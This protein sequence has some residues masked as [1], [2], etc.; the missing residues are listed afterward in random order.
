MPAHIQKSSIINRPTN[1]GNKKQGT[2]SSLSNR[3]LF[4]LRNISHRAPPPT[5]TSKRTIS[6]VNQLGAYSFLPSADG[7]TNKYRNY[8]TTIAS[9]FQ[10]TGSFDMDPIFNTSFDHKSIEI[11]ASGIGTTST[12]GFKSA[13]AEDKY[14]SPHY[15]HIGAPRTPNIISPFP[16]IAEHI[17]PDQYYANSSNHYSQGRNLVSNSIPSVINA[18]ANA[19][20]HQGGIVSDYAIKKIKVSYIPGTS[21]NGGD[22]PDMFTNLKLGRLTAPEN[23]YL[24]FFDKTYN[25]VGD[26][27]ILWE[28]KE[29]LSD[30]DMSHNGGILTDLSGVKYR[31]KGYNAFIPYLLTSGPGATINGVPFT[32]GTRYVVGQGA[33][34]PNG[35]KYTAPAAIPGYDISGTGA[36]Y[37]DPHLKTPYTWD[38]TTTFGPYIK[39][40]I[41]Y[42][43][44]DN[45]GSPE[46]F[47]EKTYTYTASNIPTY[48]K[49]VIGFRIFQERE[50]SGGSDVYGIRYVETE[51]DYTC[52]HPEY[53]ILNN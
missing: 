11:S 10:N 50:T 17:D 33:S 21:Y 45:N 15:I 9:T 40:L 31:W 53:Y 39:Q 25:K 32:N 12:D 51:I 46:K 24:E 20:Q 28:T 37:Y 43:G 41:T 52:Y 6:T 13:A 2:S 35:N 16:P 19:S 23:L 30:A 38:G 49:G 29:P 27:H 8:T 5:N 26:R 4:V 18:G 7:S 14:S 34:N 44:P 1:G 42:T 3:S 36:D 22:K 48:K 47:T